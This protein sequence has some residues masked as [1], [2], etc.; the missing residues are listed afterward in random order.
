[1]KQNI[2][3]YLATQGFTVGGGVGRGVKLDGQ[4][5]IQ[6]ST[7]PA[8]LHAATVGKYC[9]SLWAGPIYRILLWVSAVLY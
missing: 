9:W 4:G 7:A 5:K 1:M 6:N 8:P 2:V 3:I